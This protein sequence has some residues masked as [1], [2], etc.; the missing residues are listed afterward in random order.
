MWKVRVYSPSICPEPDATLL[1]SYAH[2]TD[3]VPGDSV[4]PASVIVIIKTIL[5]SPS[6]VGSVNSCAEESYLLIC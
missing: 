4:T 5:E 1:C 3:N 6:S 2:P